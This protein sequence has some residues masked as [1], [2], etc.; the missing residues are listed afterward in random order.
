MTCTNCGRETHRLRIIYPLN[1]PKL[2][3]CDKCVFAPSGVI[4]LQQ[5]PGVRANVTVAHLKDI[6]ER[7]VADPEAVRTELYHNRNRRYFYEGAPR[8][9]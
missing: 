3:G 5:A 1:G 8:H 4:L 2:E 9:V 7:K 6:H